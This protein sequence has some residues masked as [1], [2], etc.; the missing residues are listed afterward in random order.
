MESDPRSPTRGVKL[1]QNSLAMCSKYP[2]RLRTDT[3]SDLELS[4][5]PINNSAVVGSHYDP[6][7]LSSVDGADLRRDLR[8]V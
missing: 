6:E 5:E 3:H 8:I 2:F 1:P 7:V 4:W